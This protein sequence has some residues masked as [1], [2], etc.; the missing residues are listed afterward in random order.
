[1]PPLEGNQ[2]AEGTR[3]SR[4]SGLGLMLAMSISAPLRAETVSTDQAAESRLTRTCTPIRCS[5]TTR[6]CFSR[7]STLRSLAT[8]VGSIASVTTR[9]ASRRPTRTSSHPAT[10]HPTRGLAR[11]A[12]GAHGG[13]R[14]GVADRSRPPVVRSL[15]PQFRLSCFTGDRHRSGALSLRRSRLEG[16]DTRPASRKCCVPRQRSSAP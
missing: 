7:R 1:M 8:W 2:Y 6:P 5:T 14:S 15:Y 3:S 13:L 9:V 4:R 16:R 10:T 12:G 11:P